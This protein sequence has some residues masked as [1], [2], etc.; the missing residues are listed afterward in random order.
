MDEPARQ[1]LEKQL[2]NGAKTISIRMQASIETG[3]ALFA[4]DSG[5]GRETGGDG[6]VLELRVGAPPATPPALPTSEVI[7]ATLTP[8][9]ENVLTVIAQ[10]QTATAV[11]ATTGTY[12]PVPYLIVTPTPFPA[13]LE[14]VQAV[15]RA[16]DLP[17]VVR[18]TRVP[19]NAVAATRDAEYATAVALT[20]GTFTPVPANYVTPM[21]ILPS[22]P[23][24]N[25]ATA[26]ARVVAA[27]AIAARGGP[28]PTPLPYNGVIAIYVYAT[29]QPG[30]SATAIANNVVATAD[31]QVNGTAT[32]LPWNAVI[33]TAVPTP[34]EPTATPLPLLQAVTEFTPTPTPAAPAIVPDRLP[35]N[36]RNKILFKT[37]RGGGEQVYALDPA[38]GELFRINEP[39]VY[40]LAQRQ[41]ALAPDG[42]SEARVLQAA[43]RTLQIHIYS[44]EYDQTRQLTALSGADIGISAINYDP[45]W[46]PVGD[47][48]AFVSTNN[49]NDEIYTVSLDG[50]VV[51]QLTVNTFEWDKHPSWSP[52]GAQIVFFSNRETGRRQLWI[53]NADGSNQRNLSSNAYEDWDPIWVW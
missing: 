44:Y 16:L 13:N 17:P 9:P 27:T 4:W 31:A 11:A 6:P 8:I 10:E 35:D 34:A 36:L 41:L 21:I 15:A 30:N 3:D 32:P 25:V 29:E 53:M 19:P 47:R 52:D 39:W 42:R 45:A 22:P 20:T 48:V 1:W 28:T 51:K 7:V 23:A 50:A 40:P 37:D 49:G 33:I 18:S 14:T 24:E 2:R 12:T 43:D 38:N 5:V 46:S 26:A